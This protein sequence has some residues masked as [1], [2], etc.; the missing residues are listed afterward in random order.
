M[1]GEVKM[2]P[3][4]SAGTPKRK[5]DKPFASDCNLD[6]KSTTILIKLNEDGFFNQNSILFSFQ[7]IARSTRIINQL[8]FLIAI[9]HF[10]NADDEYS[11]HFE[12]GLERLL[13][14]DHLKSFFL[15][16]NQT[17]IKFK[18]IITA[19]IARI[20]HRQVS[21]LKGWRASLENLSFATI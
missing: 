20:Y 19:L 16:S 5:N 12:S 14:C 9:N 13:I 2:R 15:T 3:K 17:F 7:D 4:K 6:W 1:I 11:L 21:S 10:R 18:C 8:H